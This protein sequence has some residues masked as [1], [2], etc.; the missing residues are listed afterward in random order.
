MNYSHD[1]SQGHPSQSLPSPYVALLLLL[2]LL[3]LLLPF[4]LPLLLLL[5]FLI[6]AVDHE[7]VLTK[8]E[9][10]KS[11]NGPT[12]SLVN[13]QTN[14]PDINDEEDDELNQEAGGARRKEGRMQEA[15]NVEEYPSVLSLPRK[16]PSKEVL[17]DTGMSPCNT[18][19]I[20]L[21]YFILFYFIL[22]HFISFHFIL[23][24]FISFH[25]I[26]FYFISFYSIFRLLVYF[27]SSN[28]ITGVEI[29]K[30]LERS[31]SCLLS[32]STYRAQGSSF[33]L[34]HC[35][36]LLAFSHVHL[37]SC[38][39][40]LINLF[41]APAAGVDTWAHRKSP[42]VLSPSLFVAATLRHHHR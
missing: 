6:Y 4:P 17:V 2:F 14:D 33:I 8:T 7:R 22:F 27:Q 30:T 11:T 23:F 19:L 13:P 26:L 38:L 40:L 24:Y 25:F 16:H 29:T 10:K 20:F 3:P 21:F 28:S 37:F 1:P 39:S 41:R 9:S 35:S 15:K 36:P 32:Y 12:R 34:W 42:D 5:Y 31:P 18:S